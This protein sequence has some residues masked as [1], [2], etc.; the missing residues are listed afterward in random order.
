MCSG[1]EITSSSLTLFW[2]VAGGWWL[3]AGGS[4]LGLFVPVLT[5]G[6]VQRQVRGL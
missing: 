6:L 5:L 1:S 2:L 4:V 3:V